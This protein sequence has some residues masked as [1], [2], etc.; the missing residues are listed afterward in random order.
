MKCL[1]CGADIYEG[2]KKCPYCKTPT[3]GNEEGK[4]SNYDIKY[5]I[6]STEELKAISK[7]EAGEAVKD[8]FTSRLKRKKIYDDFAATP[9]P[10]PKA[11]DA[12]EKAREI[13]K[14]AS[15]RA[16]EFIPEGTARYVIRGLEHTD[17]KKTETPIYT[18]PVYK[19]AEKP[20]RPAAEPKKKAKRKPRKKITLPK[21]SFNV[22]K[23]ALIKFGAAALVLVLAVVLISLVSSSCSKND[24]VVSS[25]TYVKDNTLYMTYKGKTSV[26]TQE[27]MSDSF[28]RYTESTEG[29][30]SIAETAKKSAI[31]H[32]TKDGKRTFFFDGFNPETNSGTLKMVKSGKTKKVVEIAPAV[33]NSMV[34]T[35]DGKNI[36]FLQTTD[37]NG[38]MGVLHYWNDKMDEPFKI[39][40]DIDH[41]TFTFAGDGQWAMFIQ[42]FNRVEMHGDLYAKSLKKLD[43]EKVKVDT[44]VCKVYGTN[45]GGAAYIYA[46]DYDTTEKSF[47][48]YAI[49]NKNR[50]IR[51]GERTKR[52]PL[53]QKTKDKLFVYGIMDDGTNNLYTVDINNGK[54]EKIASGMNSIL[55]LSKDEKTVIYDK[56]YTGKLADYYAYVKGKQPQMIASNVVV[57][58]NTVANK[59]QMAALADCS[60]VIY[61][62]EFEAFKGGGTLKSTTFKKGKIVSEEQISEDV[63]AVW[64]GDDGKFI[65]AKDFSTTRKIFDVYLLDKGELTLLKEEVSPER[66][67]VSP[68]GKFIYAVSGYD[69]EG[70][71]G[72]LEKINLKGEV[73]T[74]A[75]Q[76]FDFEITNDDDLLIYKN[77]NTEDGSFD[78]QLKLKNKKKIIEVDGAVEKII[79]Y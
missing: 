49:N 44:A 6:N 24:D 61:I 8:S 16:A 79:G 26:V 37:E 36:L 71:F 13:A 22:N 62:A 67:G 52:D 21:L 66:F 76:V 78:L 9:V 28:V 75:E 32:E 25:Y 46:K 70:K 12:Q 60:Q 58:Y 73:Q 65:V 43:E 54:K 29:A 64:R 5:T 35:K 23:Q 27:L 53:M 1:E 59:P 51:L 33:H 41:G 3:Q 69:V 55:M 68:D 48:I 45:P 74:V 2:V 38:D 14:S 31:I 15:Q 42:N 77:L 19:E 30:P 57:D 47:D 18:P 20:V 10:E 63:Y 17:E 40:T 34:M 56:V 50:S 39:A 7:A 11:F 4:F 72:T